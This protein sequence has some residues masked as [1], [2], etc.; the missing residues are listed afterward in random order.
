MSTALQ[1]AIMHENEAMSLET[2]KK[3]IK[4]MV[5]LFDTYDHDYRDEGIK[6]VA[7]EV[8]KAKTDLRNILRKHPNWNED[9]QYV[10]TEI[11]IVRPI[12]KDAISDFIYWC[13]NQLQFKWAKTHALKIGL[14]DAC[15]YKSALY[16]TE[17]LLD[18][19]ITNVTEV[20]GMTK[21]Q[22]K[23]DAER[24]RKRLRE[25]G[26]YKI[27]KKDEHTEVFI[28]EADYNKYL[29]E[30]IL[31]H[32]FCNCESILSEANANFLNELAE[33]CEVD[34]RARKGQKLS[35]V[36]NKACTALELNKISD[37]RLK[38]FTNPDTGEVSTRE[39]ECGYNAKYAT[40]ADASSPKTFKKKL[41]LSI[42]LVDFLT[43]SFGD[44]WASCHTIDYENYRHCANTYQGQYRS[45][46]LSYAL[47]NV[48]L[49]AY[50]PG[51]EEKYGKYTKEKR[52]MFF[53]GEEKLQQSL[54]YPDGRDGGNIDYN[55]AFRQAIQDIFAYCLDYKE[56]WIYKEGEVYINSY[57]THYPDYNYGRNYKSTSFMKTEEGKN[58]FS[59]D[60]GHRPICII[61]GEEHNDAE[62][63]SDDSDV[64]RCPN[65]GSRI[66]IDY[67]DYE[68]ARD[69]WGDNVYF[70]DAD[71]AEG[72]GYV[73]CDNVETY[74]SPAHDDVY[75]D[76]YT[77]EYFYDNCYEFIHFD[78]HHYLDSENANNDGWVHC[79]D[80]DE[81]HRETDAH[82]DYYEDDWFYDDS[83]MV[84]VGVLHFIDAE[85]AISYGCVYNEEDDEWE[86][87]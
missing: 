7:D 13:K 85:N 19:F 46:T 36:M 31:I 25:I 6:R 17:D 59:I 68:E 57:G 41:R 33:K 70:C 27:I 48:S 5:Y 73:W 30:T 50:I 22:I 24:M 10:E 21:V 55:T 54:L 76:D 26:Y 71:C 81:W 15:E 63:L 39:V 58:T 34:L 12:D 75:L 29:N 86:V 51:N 82:Y 20:R 62:S 42:A 8:Y 61:S 11:E 14:H 4:E 78:G 38:S 83:E 23:A 18:C 79:F 43:M 52:Q 44:N 56:K 2:I 32:E 49:V 35:K 74:Y 9:G 84:T 72:E 53:F 37:V 60:V 16:R 80:D 66:N 28:S 67:D 1:K 64:Y 65:C 3:A 47:D 40:F 77:Q 69:S 87:Q 45:G